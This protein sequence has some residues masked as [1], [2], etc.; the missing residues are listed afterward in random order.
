MILNKI[1]D[2]ILNFI[3]F[4][5]DG[6]NLHVLNEEFLFNT[7]DNLFL[8]FKALYDKILSIKKSDNL[9]SEELKEQFL[10]YFNFNNFFNE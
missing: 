1:E 8:S 10:T 3:N 2:I 5:E 6:D 9:H 7:K 4:C